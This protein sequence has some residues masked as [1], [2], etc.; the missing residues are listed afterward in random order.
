[1]NDAEKVSLLKEL[2]TSPNLLVMPGVYDPVSA[3]LAEEAG[4]AALQCSG[5]AISA[6]HYGV[7]DYSIV[8]L[9]EM[10]EATGRVA[11]SVDVPVMGDGDTGFGNAVNAYFT[12]QAFECCGAAG[13][14][15]EDQV[16]PKRC[17]HLDGKTVIGLDEAVAKIAAAAGARRN[18]DFV[19]NARTDALA[20]E[21]IDGVIRRGN[22]YLEAGATMVFVEGVTSRDVISAAVQGID[23]PVAVNII[24]GGKSPQKL[25]FA[26]LQELGV[27]RVSLPGVVFAAAIRGVTDALAQVR[28]DGGT[29]NLADRTASFE[30]VHELSGTPLVRKLEDTYLA[31][32]AGRPEPAGKE[33]GR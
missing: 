1:M 21:G 22:A 14:N 24:D 5:L 10:A 11:R 9:G 12:V 4:F 29:W 27:A 19:I 26:E 33:Q 15:L 20:V 6:V 31:G 7:P 2:I 17:G 28:A 13:V 8:S 25:T 30:Q 16:M 23:G 3:K 18:P 32:L